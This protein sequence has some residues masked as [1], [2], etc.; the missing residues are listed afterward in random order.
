M[1][2]SL[3][4]DHTYASRTIFRAN[5][6]NSK[7]SPQMRWSYLIISIILTILTIVTIV[8]SVTIMTIM[9]IVTIV[10]IM[11]IVTIVIIVIIVITYPLRVG[12][13]LLN[14]VII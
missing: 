2:L 9:T 14:T 10:T 4:Y 11:T 12:G 3:A 7:V 8:T 1:I 5:K 6:N 13:I